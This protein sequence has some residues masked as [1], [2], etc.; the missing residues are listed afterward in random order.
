[1]PDPTAIDGLYE[2]FQ[3]VCAYALLYIEEY[4]DKAEVEELKRDIALLSRRFAIPDTTI[5]PDSDA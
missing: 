5:K 3:T 4:G 2:A 1:V